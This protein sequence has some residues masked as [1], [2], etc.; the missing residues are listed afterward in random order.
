MCREILWFRIYYVDAFYNRSASISKIAYVEIL[1]KNNRPLLQQKASL[2]PGEADGS[3]V[4]PVNIPSGVYHLRAY[5]NW[6]KN[7]SP[8]YYFDKTIRII[9]PQNLKPD[10]AVSQLKQYDIQ[11]FPEGGNLVQNLVT[12]VAF[13]ITNGYGKGINCDG[14]ILN[15]NADTVLKFRPLHLGLGNFEFKPVAGQTYTAVIRL[16]NGEKITKELPKSYTSGYVMNLS[17][18]TEGQI[19]VK[20]KSSPDLDV[21]QYL[22]FVH[23]THSCLPVKSLKI[24]QQQSLIFINP[25]SLDDGISQFTLF[26]NIGQPVCERLYFKYPEN[27]LSISATTNSA[28]GSREKV[29]VNVDV[30]DETGKPSNADMSLA[31]YRLDSLQHV[32]ETDIRNYLYLTAELGPVESPGFYFKDNGKYREADMDNL[33]M[34][35]GWRR[36]LWNDIRKNA[37]STLKFSPEYDGHIIWGKLVNNNTGYPVPDISV[38]LSIPSARTEFRVTTSVAGGLFKFEVPGFY[39]SQEIILQTNPDED[40]TCHPE[41][42]NP[43]S[44]KYAVNPMAEYSIPSDITTILDQSIAEQVQHI[45]S[46]DRL[47]RFSKQTLDT[48][49]FYVEPDEKYV[50]DNYT[51]F[52]TMEEVIREYVVSTNVTMK[53]NKFQVQLVNKPQGGYFKYA[54]LI[55][56]DG[57]PYFDANELFQQ[58]P[59]KIRRL[60]LVN[61]QYFLGFNYFNGVIN[62]TTYNGDLNGIQ[63]NPRATVLDYPGIPEQREFFSPAYETEDQVNSPIPDFRTLLY[64]AP[65]LKS[66]FENKKTIGFYTSDLPGKYAVVI[67]GLSSKGEPG[68]QV[69]YFSVNK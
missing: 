58:D 66:E 40:S 5:T 33:M 32:D 35:Q 23:G 2:K 29:E 1:D 10:S 50:L 52:Q 9:N 56:I 42:I 65:E 54:P 69:V 60:D 51:R 46:G 6:M 48:N 28:Y 13:R 27:K 11:F 20:I 64:W 43:F 61:R 44:D 18:T 68:S 3:F 8:N 15:S 53:R 4:I 36:F 19:A 22:L 24:D 63:L 21:Q 12:R 49:S 41:I 55:L 7:F 14:I 57:V 26:N 67:M 45:Y 38:Y 47:N 30:T 17:K 39:G 25:E 34:T 31:V 37:P 62:A 16:T 59:L